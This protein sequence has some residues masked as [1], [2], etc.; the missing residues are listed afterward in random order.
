MIDPEL[1]KEIDKEFEGLEAEKLKKI[2][3]FTEKLQSKNQE[4]VSQISKSEVEKA[5]KEKQGEYEKSMKEKEAAEKAAQEA[6]KKEFDEFFLKEKENV[7]R[8]FKEQGVS[9]DDWAKK[10]D[11][12]G[13]YGNIAAVKMFAELG[14]KYEYSNGTS[15]GTPVASPKTK[16]I[17][18]EIVE[19]I[20][21]KRKGN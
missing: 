19:E 13:V 3:A 8:F 11:E 17:F 20:E 12:A 15:G 21:N 9:A 5:L 18:A 4:V 6:K 7:G 10:L 1:Q 2:Y 16:S 14:K